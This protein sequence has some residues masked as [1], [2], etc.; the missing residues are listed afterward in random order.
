MNRE[1]KQ[2]SYV[3]SYLVRRAS[4]PSRR[5]GLLVLTGGLAGALLVAL[6][7]NIIYEPFLYRERH[8]W[9]NQFKPD[10]ASGNVVLENNFGG[11]RVY[12]EKCINDSKQT[13]KKC[14]EDW[15][16][17]LTSVPLDSDEH[18]SHEAEDCQTRP[19]VVPEECMIDYVPFEKHVSYS[20]ETSFFEFIKMSFLDSGTYWVRSNSFF[21]LCILL[22][23][24]LYVGWF[25]RLVRWIKEG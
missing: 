3:S 20:W 4:T 23:I 19:Y 10:I 17:N 24:V 7:W 1:R 5:L 16:R 21:L 2:S 25:D 12:D 15:L 6:V 18:L 9:V 14:R 11:W 8:V 22:G 13:Y